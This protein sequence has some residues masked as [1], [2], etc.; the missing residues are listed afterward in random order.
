MVKKLVCD[1]CRVELTEKYDI[2]LAYE[3][4]EAWAAAARARGAEPRGIIPCEHFIS[5]GGEMKLVDD[6]RIVRC[7][8]WLMKLFRH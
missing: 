6:S 5:C 3:G 8:L 7:R 4:K 1:R 2:D